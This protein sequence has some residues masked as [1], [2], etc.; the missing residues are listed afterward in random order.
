MCNSGLTISDVASRTGVAEATL[1]MWESRHAFPSPSRSGAGHRRYSQMDVELIQRVVSERSSGLSLAAAIR[2]ARDDAPRPLSVYASLRTRRPELEPRTI[3]VPLLLALTRALEDESLSRASR[4]L[5]FASFQRQT[6]YQR[7]QTRWTEL[8]RGARLSVV[9][10][11]F[12]RAHAAGDG[13]IELPIEPTHPLAREWALVCCAADHAACL[14]AWEPPGQAERPVRE[15]V[16]ETIWSV[17]AD[18]VWTA[19]RV[20]AGVARQIVPEQIATIDSVLERDPEPSSDEQARL[21]TAVTA[22]LLSYLS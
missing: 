5:L 8:A 6:A 1:R 20:C 21:S 13:P 12:D 7:Q 16:F 14:A 22:R 17:D 15:R 11:D 10:A 18:A 9:F 4:P 3:R 2:R 19:A